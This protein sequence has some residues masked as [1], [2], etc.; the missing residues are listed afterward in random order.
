MIEVR[1]KH[2]S[3]AYSPMDVIEFGRL[4]DVRD[5]QRAKAPPERELQLPP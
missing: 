5:E 3:K 4:I 1:D 2:T